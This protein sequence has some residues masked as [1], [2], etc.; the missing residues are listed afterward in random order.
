MEP[1]ETQ[2]SPLPQTDGNEVLRDIG[3]SAAYCAGSR[4][5]DS[6]ADRTGELVDKVHSVIGEAQ[7]AKAVAIYEPGTNIESIA[8]LST[9]GSVRSL[10]SDIFDEYRMRPKAYTGTASMTRID[11]FIA[12]VNRFKD[13]QS[14]LFAF[15]NMVAPRLTAVLDYNQSRDGGNFDGPRFGNHRTQFAFPLSEEWKI[16]TGKNKVKMDLA[17][18]AEFI[19]DRF[20][21]V[22]HVNDVSTLNDDVQKLLATVGTGSIASPSKLIELSRGLKVHVKDEVAGSVSLSS[23]EGEVQFK[24]EHTDKY[25]NKLTVPSLFVLNIPV[26]YQDGLY[27]VA[28]RL[29]YRVEGGMMKFWYELW[30]LERVFEHAFAEACDSA[31]LHTALPLFYGTPE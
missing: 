15:D 1:E 10:P 27:R 31:A 18:F 13:S 23:G 20:I 4:M 3:R 16:W 25:G 9:D 26:F 30:G 24:T 21:D 5:N 11:S 12:H 19:E 28:A 2:P 22:E 14:A 17:Q 8:V 29:R 7:R 6:V